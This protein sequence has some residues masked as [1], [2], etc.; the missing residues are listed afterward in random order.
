MF[1]DKEKAIDILVELDCFYNFISGKTIQ[2]PASTSIALESNLKY[3][4]MWTTFD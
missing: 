1:N 2:S 4:N 3:V